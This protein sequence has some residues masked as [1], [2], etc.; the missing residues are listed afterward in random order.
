[1]PSTS[2][3]PG[4]ICVDDSTRECTRVELLNQM[5]EAGAQTPIVGE[6][7]NE[8]WRKAQQI[9]GTVHVRKGDWWNRLLAQQAL[10]FVHL[11]F[12]YVEDR[13][14]KDCYRFVESTVQNGGECKA[15]NILLTAILLRLGLFAE[16]YW[17]DQKGQPLN[18]VASKVT[19]DGKPL[20]ADASV[21]GAQLG[22]SPYQA[23]LRTGAWHVIGM[24]NP[25]LQTK[26]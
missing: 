24:R 4:L 17:I 6:L 26:S 1:M 12:P 21:F 16:V 14:G 9:A 2:S 20:W 25:R 7:A 13:S 3:Q 8:V 5:A 23:I 18:H 10:F 19:I 15:L 11:R 22:E